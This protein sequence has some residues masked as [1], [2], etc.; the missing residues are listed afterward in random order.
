M[1]V[2]AQIEALIEFLESQPDLALG[3]CSRT[4]EGRSLAKRLWVEC[5]QILNSVSDDC[6]NKTPDEWRSFYNEY[7]SKLVKKI[8]TQMREMSMTGGAAKAKPLTPLQERLYDILGRDIGETFGD[9]LN[10]LYLSD[11]EQYPKD[12]CF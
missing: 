12:K 6:P 10:P 11:N 4:L 8:K 3:R 2:L 5:A 9:R 7:K 1:V